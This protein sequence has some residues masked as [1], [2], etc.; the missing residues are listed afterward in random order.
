[1][2]SKFEAEVRKVLQK[3]S[4]MYNID[5]SGIDVRFDIRKTAK[6]AGQAVIK[7]G[8][9]YL[10]FH[11]EAVENH[12]DYMVKET[13]PHEVAHTVCQMLPNLGCNHDHGWSQVCKSLGGMSSRC[14]NLEI[15]HKGFLYK[16]ST[17][18][19][20]R[21]SLIRHNKLQRRKVKYYTTTKLGEIYPENYIGD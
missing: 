10:R 4:K 12:F 16:T 11:P 14:H 18:E 21:L 5:I 15:G 17:G 20:I 7:D 8:T 9:C 1:M 3:A 6:I 19:S 13:I 2:K